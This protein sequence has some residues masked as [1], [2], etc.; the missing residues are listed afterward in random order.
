MKKK[1]P[2]PLTEY[3]Q[4]FVGAHEGGFVQGHKGRHRCRRQIE[5]MDVI[6]QSDV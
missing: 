5:M 3:W 4:M 6:L 2:M 1:K